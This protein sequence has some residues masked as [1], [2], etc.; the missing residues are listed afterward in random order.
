MGQRQLIEMGIYEQV[1]RNYINYAVSWF[2]RLIKRG[3]P[4]VN[5]S[6]LCKL[7]NEFKENYLETLGIAVELPDFFYNKKTSEAVSILREMGTKYFIRW[8][9]H[10]SVI[11]DFW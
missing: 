8:I 3:E 9:K 7:T 1:G 4:Y 2:M 6:D 10:Y 11:E 5:T